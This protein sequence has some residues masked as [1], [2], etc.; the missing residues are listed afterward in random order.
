MCS[1]DV[2]QTVRI[3]VLD[4][5]S[6]AVAWL[7]SG[8]TP[9]MSTT[10][11]T[12]ETRVTAV[13]LRHNF[14]SS[15]CQIQMTCSCA[16]PAS[17]L[18]N[19]IAGVAQAAD[20][21]LGVGYCQ[22]RIVKKFSGGRSMGSWYPRRAPESFIP[23]TMTLRVSTPNKSP[24]R[25]AQNTMPSEISPEQWNQVEAL[26]RRTIE[27]PAADRGAFLDSVCSGDIVL[28]SR[29][30]ALLFSRHRDPTSIELPDPDPAGV[31][32]QV[33]VDVQSSR[34]VEFGIGSV[35]SGK[36]VIESLIGSGGMGAV[37]R[38]RQ[39][40]LDRPVAIKVVLGKYQSSDLAVERFRREAV[41]VAK[42]RHPNI[43][44]VYDFGVA[45]ESGTYL[46]ME[47][48][49]GRSL[50]AELR[51]HG[52][53]PVATVLA[54]ASQVGAALDAAHRAGVI[55]RD[56][57]PDNVY[58]AETPHGTVAKILDFGVAK[59]VDASDPDRDP[60]TGANARIGTPAY[61]S[62]EQCEGRT[63][64][65]RSD[66]Y[67]LGGTVFEM[68][69]GRPP[70][71]ADSI[72][73]LIYQHVHNPPEPPSRFRPGLP[74]AV[75]LAVLRALAKDPPQRFASASELAAALASGSPEW[76]VEL[77]G[78]IPSVG[79]EVA[80][81]HVGLPFSATAGSREV[82]ETAPP[83]N[84]PSEVTS[85][86]GREHDVSAG[87]RALSQGRVVTLTGPGG[88]GKTRLALRI[89]ADSAREFADGVWLVELA[90]IADASLVPATVATAIGVQATA[91]DPVLHAIVNW[92][93]SHRALIVLDNCEHVIEACASFVAAVVRSGADVKILATSREPLAVEGESVRPVAPLALPDSGPMA[94]IADLV[95]NESVRLFAERA[96]LAKPGF[97]IEERNAH[98]VAT[99]CRRLDGIPLAIELA[100]AR[101][102]VL[103]VEQILERMEDRFRLLT[104]GSRA[105][106]P[107]HQTLRA[108]IDWSY[109][110]LTEDERTLLAR[111]SVFAGGCSLDAAE[112]VCT[113]EGIDE[114]TLLDLLT[115]LV[116]RSL[117]VFA[118]AGAT[119]RYTMLE[120]IREYARERLIES[121]DE[122]PRLA[123]HAAW[124]LDLVT[125][126]RGEFRGPRQV[127][128]YDR[129]QLEHDNLR[130]ALEWA[131][132]TSGDAETSARIAGALA[133]FWNTRGHTA[134]GRDWT[135]AALAVDGRASDAAR[136]DAL[137]GL[138]LLAHATGDYRRARSA[139][140]E[141][142]RIRKSIG[143]PS[144]IARAM[145]Y[146]AVVLTSMGDYSEAASVQ[147]E[148][149]ELSRENGL[150][151][152][153]NYGVYS[154]GM[155]AYQT[156]EL[157]DAVALLESSL[158]GW[159]GTGHHVAVASVLGTLGE[160]NRLLGR[161][162]AAEAHFNEAIELAGRIDAR[163]LGA[164]ARAGL[165]RLLT[166][167]GNLKLAASLLVEA[168]ATIRREGTR[169]D[170]AR[171][172]ESCAAL[173]CARDDSATAIVLLEASDAERKRSGAIR[174]PVHEQR[175]DGL[176]DSASAA[177]SAE[178]SAVA[179]ARG[180]SL[181]LDA[182]L[183]LA[184][185]PS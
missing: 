40:D 6:F 10:C 92:T 83:S 23:G 38:A 160:V 29:V 151:D 110:M 47:H 25:R 56:V 95:S 97:D 90:S 68:L 162:E 141:C 126:L 155:I 7:S 45:P 100:A 81:T 41:A 183:E 130:A 98:V 103:S 50:R 102:R 80:V 19:Q 176:R 117:V 150:A 31:A 104:G 57:K 85:F 179:G 89:A 70:F 148:S 157:D 53:L 127:E 101:A 128:A 48:L 91:G 167:T 78:S 74:H 184:L 58:L 27:Q 39:S 142:V 154:L 5:P 62:P 181:T 60:L 116:D 11:G 156:A 9:W 32:T 177:L 63:V 77:P 139:I 34:P 13:L 26:Y 67:A 69:T 82:V 111:L 35:L 113:G 178:E 1:E 66:V 18:Q 51:Q 17:A 106:L 118:E 76:S 54:I 86:V 88:I 112:F 145:N 99:L 59:L 122:S 22:L 131:I 108:T 169:E 123:A 121:G 115:R 84:L 3:G 20:Y 12:P 161:T 119:P 146:R 171:L 143:Q 71:Q 15:T 147:R 172:V 170:L 24:R 134:E 4:R 75:E 124:C 33:T 168:A 173:A 61:M 163:A 14:F 140:E 2:L 136:D 164:S 55:H 185:A 28:R 174:A 30:E 180:R 165:G 129:A 149:L 52:A 8:R 152:E 36:Y 105:T 120:T 125:E 114:L 175:I 137:Y 16:P 42:L 132:R 21:S 93:R 37:Y 65:R 96:R 133:M 109:R 43:V 44:T 73:S 138:S 87:R 79:S 144:A 64:D 94:S 135:E 46:V 158:E 182:A 159:R 153:A 166:D 107:H 49:E 72:S